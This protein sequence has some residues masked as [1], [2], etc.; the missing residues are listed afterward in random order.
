MPIVD[1]PPCLALACWYGIAWARCYR[2][3]LLTRQD[4]GWHSLC[5]QAS[6]DLGTGFCVNHRAA[7]DGALCAISPADQGWSSHPRQTEKA[8]EMIIISWKI[9]IHSCIYSVRLG[10]RRLNLRTGRTPLTMKSAS[11]Q[12]RRTHRAVLRI[13]LKPNEDQWKGKHH[14]VSGR[15]LPPQSTALFGGVVS[16]GWPFQIRFDSAAI[17]SGRGQP[18]ARLR[19]PIIPVGSEAQL[20]FL[21]RAV[22]SRTDD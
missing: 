17:T 10:S 14:R 1:Y 5:S 21:D 22:D 15:R 2:A 9:L 7:L 3:H 19:L 12:S 4:G 16:S 18:A 6:G 20:L 13:T 8:L 11:D